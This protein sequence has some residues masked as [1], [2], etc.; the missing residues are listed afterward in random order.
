MLR[1]WRVCSGRAGAVLRLLFVAVPA[2]AE[3]RRTSNSGAT[4]NIVNPVAATVFHKL[5]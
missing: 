3:L 1:P 2:F 5:L 4:G